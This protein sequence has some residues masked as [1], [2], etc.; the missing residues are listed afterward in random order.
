MEKIMLMKTLMAFIAAAVGL[1]LASGCG[2]KKIESKWTDNALVVDGKVA[3]GD[4]PYEYW[5]KDERVALSVMNDGEY[6]YFL[7]SAGSRALARMLSDQGVVLW[8]DPA[9]ENQ[10]TYGLR[11]IEGQDTIKVMKGKDGAATRVPARGEQGPAFA[12][13]NEEGSYSYEIRVP[14][15]AIP[16]EPGKKIGLGLEFTSMEVKVKKK[17]HSRMHEGGQGGMG[18]MG[19]MGGGMGRQPMGRQGP[20]PDEEDEKPKI[21]TKLE[22][23]AIWLKLVLAKKAD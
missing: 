21:E 5:F 3:D 15:G 4:F 19:G 14:L 10:K 11:L 1:F 12:V 23:K 6:V 2:G 8:F 17:T 9:G 16:A 18:G 20:D 13:F 22:E 7:F